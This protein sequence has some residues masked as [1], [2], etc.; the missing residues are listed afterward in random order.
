MHGVSHGPSL[1]LIL[2][3]VHDLTL[4][5]AGL[6][7]PPR[8]NTHVHTPAEFMDGGTLKKVVSRQM[9]DVSRRL[10][11]CADAFRWGLQVAEGEAGARAGEQERGEGRVGAE[12]EVEG[13][14]AQHRQAHTVAVA[15]ATTT[16]HP[17]TT[18]VTSATALSRST[19][20]PQCHRTGVPARGAAAG[21]PPRPEAR[22][23]AACVCGDVCVCICVCV[24]YRGGCVWGEGREGGSK[25]E[26]SHAQCL[27]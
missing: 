20:S 23:A 7:L 15:G 16:T 2:K 9:I 12:R 17:A 10:Y 11:S 8:T 13:R 21:H 19:P 6:L 14:H 25:G 26:M 5:D 1:N 18:T 4:R 27:C 22:G 24:C 3:A